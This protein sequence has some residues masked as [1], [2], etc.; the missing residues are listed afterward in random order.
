M[1]RLFRVIYN[2]S[3]ECYRENFGRGR[4]PLPNERFEV[5]RQHRRAQQEA[6]ELIAFDVAEEG[7]L[8]LRLHALGN[9]PQVEAAGH[10]YNRR[11]DGGVI[12]IRRYVLNKG[13]VDLDRV[14]REALE[15]TK[16]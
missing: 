4:G 14:D 10:R 9:D 12:L 11:D 16:R 2:E 6:L 8:R 7:E 15:V 1:I 5:V 3:A 13:A